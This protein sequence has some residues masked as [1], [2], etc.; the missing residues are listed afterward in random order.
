MKNRC[1]WGT[2]NPLLIEYH[3]T[4]WGAALHDYRKITE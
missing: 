2:T 1:Q 4:E 3:D